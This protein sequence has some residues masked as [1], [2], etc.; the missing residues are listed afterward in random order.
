MYNHGTFLFDYEKALRTQS[1]IA[2]V[3][4]LEKLQ[5]LFR[6]NIP[7][8]N[9]FVTKVE[10]SR[11]EL[12]LDATDIASFHD[13]FLRTKLELSMVTP[14]V[15]H[16]DPAPELEYVDYP[17]NS[18]NKFKYLGGKDSG[19]AGSEA[20]IYAERS[21]YLR[22]TWT[23]GGANRISS[24]RFVNW[25]LARTQGTRL[26][27]VN[28]LD[29]V[30]ENQKLD[31]EFLEGTDRRYLRVYD[32]YRLM[33]FSFF[34]VMDDDVAYYNTIEVDDEERSSLIEASNNLGE[35]KTCYSIT[36]EVEDQTQLAYDNFVSYIVGAYNSFSEY[37]GYANDICSFNN[38][39]NEFNQSILY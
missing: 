21:K 10:L 37:Y 20:E 22:P 8:E 31:F 18:I 27:D 5:K 25:D 15:M 11:N 30:V 16:T 34:D 7:Y 28:N 4:D 3:F 24:L 33:C 13:K 9:F 17:K 39:T 19:E 32:G 14:S 36:V 2:H 38:I 12:R 23:I 29:D 35:R 26:T 6:I 1:M